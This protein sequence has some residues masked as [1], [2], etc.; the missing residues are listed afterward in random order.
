[1]EKGIGKGEKA[2]RAPRRSIYLSSFLSLSSFFCSA[3]SGRHEILNGVFE[4]VC[5]VHDVRRGG[6]ESKLSGDERTDRLVGGGGEK[7][8][9]EVAA[10]NI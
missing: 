2:M 4:I 6:G 5:L 1:M 8:E 3:L 10:D 9:E 7:G